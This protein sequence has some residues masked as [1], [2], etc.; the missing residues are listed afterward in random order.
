MDLTRVTVCKCYIL[1]D[2]NFNKK[3]YSLIVGDSGGPLVCSDKNRTNYFL[4]GVT[5]YGYNPTLADQEDVKC[6]ESNTFTAFTRITMFS[7]YI[8]EMKQYASGSVLLREKCPGRRCRSNRRC[9]R[10]RDGIVDCLA[11]EDERN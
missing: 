9:V 5:S 7:G 4:S 11:G 6:G 2:E 3:N 10:A 8:E 1:A